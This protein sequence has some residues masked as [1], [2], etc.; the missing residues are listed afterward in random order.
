VS[1]LAL[2]T[3][4]DVGSILLDVVGQSFG[5]ASLEVR[6]RVTDGQL[7]RTIEGAPTLQI[8]LEDDQRTLLRSG[9]FDR[10]I[11]LLFDD[12][13]WRSVQ[14]SKQA[15]QL[16]VTFEDRAVALLRK[17]TTPKK[18]S[19]SQMT[20]AEFALSMVRE[21]TEFGGIPF[22]CPE[23]HTVQPVDTKPLSQ[24]I[25]TSSE[26]LKAGQRKD[27]LAGGLASGLKLY[28]RSAD[29]GRTQAT[30]DQIANAERVLDVAASLGASETATLALLEACMIESN[31]TNLS[32]GDA[33]SRGILQV[34]DSTAGP[35]GIDNR[36]IE[37]C[38]NAF[39]QR[40][41]WG[42]GGA[43]TI[44]AKNPGQSSGWVAQQTQ[45]SA[46]PTRY[47]AAEPEAR[48]F[49]SAYQGLPSTGAT[50]GS[51]DQSVDV[52]L[53]LRG[54]R[55]PRKQPHKTVQADPYQFQRGGSDG[56]IED[57]WT[58]LQRLAGEVQWRCYVVD[59]AVYWVSDTTLINQK[60]VAVLS[61]QTLGVDGI[62]FDIDN[63]KDN[64]QA[65][66][67]VRAWRQAF[68]PGSALM[69]EDC[70]PANDRWLVRDV[71][72]GLF[73][74]QAS[75]SLKRATKP[76]PEPA[77]T[78]AAVTPLL[79][80]GVEH[81]LTG[82]AA[83]VYQAAVAM[84]AKHYNY[85][86]GGGH[87]KAGTPDHGVSGHAD[88]AGT[89]P[90]SEVGYDCSGSVCAV[91]AAAGL[92]FTL[93]G[94]VS[95]SGTIASSW[96]QAGEG[97]QFTVWASSVHVFIL[98][99]TKDGLVHFGTGDWGKGWDGPGLNPNLHPTAGFTPRHWPGL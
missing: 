1:A 31:L 39:L 91:L 42:K 68:P 67:T 69:L 8:T 13:W 14:V 28:V 83:T 5:N 26:K 9:V 80:G 34:R 2:A 66:V 55:T 98:F 95:T 29:G 38:A 78:T 81:G 40:G 30:A 22:I 85:V 56:S 52:L 17:I 37:Q 6:G 70:G 16:T 46:Y 88:S 57:T 51:G 18:A 48:A 74:A 92:G 53:A 44:A 47:D 32:G 20:R 36:D 63:G 75:L 82:K 77:G 41:F 43:I 45:G 73:D 21:V 23:L 58:C 50:G 4:V 62:D 87:A 11:D 12:V 96:G 71:T 60:P 10:Q 24:P 49:L 94:A 3:D 19:R 27:G 54:L 76:L 35:M 79:A 7:D 59:G 89:V 25:T 72:R 97:A 64:S 86:W 65:T 61:E 33:D 84:T 15:D 99:K 90:V 93:G